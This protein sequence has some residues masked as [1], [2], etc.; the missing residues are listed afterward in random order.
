[1]PVA[2]V[3]HSSLV[4]AAASDAFG[5]KVLDAAAGCVAGCFDAAH[6]CT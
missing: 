5:D 1:M 6:A 4:V 2:H 3:P